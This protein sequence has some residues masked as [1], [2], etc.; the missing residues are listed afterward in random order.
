MSVSL[1]PNSGHLRIPSI[2]YTFD[3]KL[4]VTVI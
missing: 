1:K 3:Y 2:K 4:K